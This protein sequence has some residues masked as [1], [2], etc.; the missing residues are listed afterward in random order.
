MRRKHVWVLWKTVTDI[1]HNTQTNLEEVYD[2]KHEAKQA[3]EQ[4]NSE[5]PEVVKFHIE[6]KFLRA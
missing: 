6:K 5:V 3:C 2:D 1:F 4:L